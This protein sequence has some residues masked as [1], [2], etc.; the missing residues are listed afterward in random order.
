MDERAV[1]LEEQLRTVGFL[2]LTPRGVSMWPL[3]R[4]GRDSVRIEPVADPT[5]LRIGDVPVYRR[6]DGQ[7]VLHR[8]RHIGKDGYFICGDHQYR[9]EFVPFS[10]VFGIMVAYYRDEKEHL[11]TERA[12]LRY[13]R[14][15]CKPSLKWRRFVLFFADLPARAKS[16]LRRRFG[17]KKGKE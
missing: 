10:W 16:F 2:V 12:Y 13:V 1:T 9:M 15:W 14:R 8:I 4:N 3:L 5:A 6:P 17:K 7:V 11:L